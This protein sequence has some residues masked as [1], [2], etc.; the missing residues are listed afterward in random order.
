[1]PSGRSQ[2]AFGMGSGGRSQGVGLMAR[3]EY[4]VGSAA[5]G[6]G[7]GNS[8]EALFQLGLIY[9]SGRDVDEDLVEAHKWFNLAAMRG[10]REARSYRMEIAQEMT[11]AEI[12][13]AQ[14]RAR[15]W[16]NAA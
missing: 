6:S 13:I 4:T 10:Q 11:R 7:I 2:I 1:M 5:S 3:Y 8:A 16:L 14:R 9:S 12:A 15:E